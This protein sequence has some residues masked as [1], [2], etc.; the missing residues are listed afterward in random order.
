VA[1][2]KEKAST[3]VDEEEATAT[4]AAMA[5][6][7]AWNCIVYIWSSGAGGYGRSVAWRPGRR[8]VGFFVWVLPFDHNSQ[9]G[10]WATKTGEWKRKEAKKKQSK[11]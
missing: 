5:A 7:A 9:R 3:A 2:A 11:K 10:G 8:R 6:T 1:G 4:A